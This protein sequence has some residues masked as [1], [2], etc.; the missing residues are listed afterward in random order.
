MNVGLLAIAATAVSLIGLVFI[1]RIYNNIDDLLF[2]LFCVGIAGYIF[3]SV[4]EYLDRNS[5]KTRLEKVEAL[6]DYA[7]DKA[8]RVN[9]KVNAVTDVLELTY[10]NLARKIKPCP[11]KRGETIY[12][13]SYMWEETVKQDIEVPITYKYTIKKNRCKKRYPALVFVTGVSYNIEEDSWVLSVEGALGCIRILV[14][15]LDYTKA[16]NVVDPCVL[17]TLKN[18]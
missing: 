14:K 11:I 1:N 18:K 9:N 8:N 7:N 13:N 3:S 16:T 12:I 10:N 17:A 2:P 4:Q 15:G 6:A 5:I